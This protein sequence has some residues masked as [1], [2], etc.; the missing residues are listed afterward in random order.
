MSVNSASLPRALGHLTCLRHL[1]LHNNQIRGLED[2]MHELRRMLQLQT[3]TFFL[4]PIS[5]E[6]GYRLHVIHCLPSIQD[7]DRKEVKAA[8]RRKSFQ[9]YNQERHLVLQSLAF[10][11][12]T[13]ENFLLPR[14][15]ASG[16]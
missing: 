10:G 5:H 2:T 16:S 4:N 3:A 6:P 1:S 14:P 13:T 12:R 11:R 9:I 7:L 8:E 15:A